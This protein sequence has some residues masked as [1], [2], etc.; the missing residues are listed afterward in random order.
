MKNEI[1]RDVVG[2]E[3]SYQVSNLGRVKSLTR[4]KRS[5]HGT[6]FPKSGRV[7]KPRKDRGGYLSV[8]LSCE[9][10][11]ATVKVHRIVA[12]AFHPNPTGLP[13][14]NHRNGVKTDN[15]EWN[16]EWISS[17]ANHAHAASSGLKANGVRNCNA[18]LTDSDIPHILRRLSAGE[19]QSS[20]SRSYGVGVSAITSI[21][22]G[23]TWKHVPRCGGLG[24]EVKKSQ[25]EV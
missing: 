1:W 23:R 3:G 6:Y 7:M 11:V 15:S 14:V 20:I 8:G 17:V 2:Y 21:K 19:S 16:L 5:R 24:H 25:E 10:V 12:M 13:Q 4:P 18:K 9:G 22:M